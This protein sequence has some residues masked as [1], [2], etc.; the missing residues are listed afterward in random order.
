MTY[1]A[2]ELTDR[3]NGWRVT[4]TDEDGNIT[5]HIIFCKTA[6]NTASK[7]IETLIEALTTG[8]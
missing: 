6:E 7:A 5:T 8:E 2:Q 1:I 4:A 3:P